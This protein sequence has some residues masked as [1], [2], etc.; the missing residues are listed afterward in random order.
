MR[1]PISLV[2]LFIAAQV[3]GGCSTHRHPPSHPGGTA[4]HYQVESN[5]WTLA[6]ARIPSDHLRYATPV[7]L[8]HGLGSNHYSFDFAPTGSLARYLAAR[9]YDGWMLDLRGQGDSERARWGKPARWSFDDLVDDIPNVIAFVAAQ[10]HQAR[11]AYIGHSMGGMIGQAHLGNGANDILA[12]VAIASPTAFT[13]H[14][15][16]SQTGKEIPRYVWARVVRIHALVRFSTLLGGRQP[17]FMD[18][19][20]WNRSNISRKEK[21][22]LMRWATDDIQR[23]VVR[24][25]ARAIERGEWVDDQGRSYVERLANITVPTLFLTGTVDV[26]CAPE[27][28]VGTFEKLGSRDKTLRIISRAN[29]YKRD[30]GHVDLLCGAAA[31]EEVFPSIDAW[32]GAHLEVQTSR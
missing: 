12:F 5:G 6:L 10:T 20:I 27:R 13:P 28:V 9:G 2:A 31:A 32:L 14:D 24:S 15:R 29:G 17:E 11:I 3:L 7:L 30:Y 19:W 23:E 26:L 8:V 16:F 4:R 18:W 22:A 1:H 25:L 21:A